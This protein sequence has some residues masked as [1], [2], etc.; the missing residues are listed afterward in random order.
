MQ[1]NLC[2]ETEVI[3]PSTRGQ[4][5]FD[6]DGYRRPQAWNVHFLSNWLNE[7]EIDLNLSN[8]NASSKVLSHA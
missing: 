5:G 8:Y 3:I 6:V 4:F 7:G 1:L 2:P